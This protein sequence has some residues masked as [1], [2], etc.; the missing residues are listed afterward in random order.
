[1]KSITEVVF[2]F[3]IWYVGL[4]LGL[5]VLCATY[6]TLAWVPDGLMFGSVPFPSD[7]FATSAHF[8]LP[9]AFVILVLGALAI[10]FE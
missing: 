10:M 1:M 4:A 8:A 9:T 6:L 7:I 2:G 5:F 3:V